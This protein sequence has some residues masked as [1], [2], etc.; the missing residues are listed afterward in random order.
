MTKFKERS[1]L[2]VILLTIFT[3][4]LYGIYWTVAT[5][6]ELVQAGA[7]VPHTILAFIPMLH[8]YFWYQYATAYVKI[9]KNN[10]E[11][12]LLYFIIG[13]FFPFIHILVFQN[14]FNHY[15]K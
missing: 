14:G 11:S 15:S 7:D 12:V 1:L 4:G 2:A 6:R 10:N 5:R 13:A 9:V 3:L 8:I